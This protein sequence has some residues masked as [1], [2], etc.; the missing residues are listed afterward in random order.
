MKDTDTPA[1]AIQQIG[2]GTVAWIPWNLGGLYYRH[3]LPA[4]AGLFRDVVDRL[5]PARQVRTNAHPLVEVTVMRQGS[6]T[7]VHLINLSGQS[8]T[9]YYTPIPMS[10]IRLQIAGNFKT[11]KTVRI[12]GAV[13]VRVNQGYTEF[14]VSK[15]ADYELVVLE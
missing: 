12:S 8:Q 11:G 9:G 3:S 2:K 4:H 1:I 5:Q 6:R 10:E 13:P 14:T 15:L 7:L